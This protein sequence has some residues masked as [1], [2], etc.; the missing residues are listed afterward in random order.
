VSLLAGPAPAFLAL[1]DFDDNGRADVAVTDVNDHT[2][3]VF[4][5]PR[6]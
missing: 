5:T 1:A 6:N 2:I 4:L 3:R